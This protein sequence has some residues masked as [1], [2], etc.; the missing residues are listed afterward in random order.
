[1]TKT[2]ELFAYLDRLIALQSAGHAVR[3]EIAEVISAIRRE[4]RSILNSE[5]T[6]EVIEVSSTE[7]AIIDVDMTRHLYPGPAKIYVETA[8]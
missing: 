1:M 3:K 8:E 5:E 7:V 6:T 2:E 4:N